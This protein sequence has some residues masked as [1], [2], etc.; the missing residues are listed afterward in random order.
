MPTP[1]RYGQFLGDLTWC[2]VEYW[3][4]G[5]SEFHFVMLVMA[6][7]RAAKEKEKGPWGSPKALVNREVFGGGGQPP[8]CD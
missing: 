3:L 8:H 2:E 4:S 7:Q 1:H 6:G 5:V